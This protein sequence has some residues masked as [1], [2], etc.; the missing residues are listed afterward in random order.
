MRIAIPLFRLTLALIL[1]ATVSSNAAAEAISDASSNTL[2]PEERLNNAIKTAEESEQ[3]EKAT[4]DKLIELYKST[5]DLQKKVI[6]QNDATTDFIQSREQSRGKVKAILDKLQEQDS[7][8]ASALLELPDNLT[9]E[10]VEQLLITNKSTVSA[11]LNTLA[12]LDQQLKSQKLRPETIRQ[13][14]ETAAQHLQDVKNEMEFPTP[15]DQL[16]LLTE[17]RRWNLGARSAAL[18]SEIE[19][20]NQELL[21]QSARIELLKAQRIQAE[22]SIKQLNTSISQLEE[23]LIQQR[24]SDIEE[25]REK[26]HTDIKES[27][28]KHPLILE[29]AEENAVLSKELEQTTQDLEELTLEKEQKT[30]RVRAIEEDFRHTREKVEIAGYSQ[31][32]GHLLLDRRRNLPDTKSFRQ[33]AKTR[34][35]LMV[36]AG[37][38]QIRHIEERRD[39]R[40]IDSHIHQM[41]AALPAQEAE[42]IQADLVKLAASRRELLDSALTLDSAYLQTLEEV[43]RAYRETL[44]TVDSYDIFLAK[45]LLWVRNAPLPTIDNLPLTMKQFSWL[46][47]PSL[48]L[49][50]LHALLSSGSDSPVLGVG[51]I[52]FIILRWNAHKLR[53]IVQKSGKPVGKPMEDHFFYTFKALIAT[54]LLALPWPFLLAISGW[55]IGVSAEA[56]AFTKAISHSLLQTSFIFFYLRSFYI[57]C[58]PGGL[59]EAHFEWPKASVQLLRREFNRFMITFLP[60]IFIAITAFHYGIIPMEKGTGRASIIL[61]QILLG[62]FFYRLIGSK[63]AILQLQNRFP[64][65]L[66]ANKQLLWVS[67]LL[68]FPVA[69]I[70]LSILGYLY[71]AGV[72]IQNLLQTMWFSLA[73]VIVQQL[74]I[75]WLVLSHR[76][77]AFKALIE[78]RKALAADAGS[79]TTSTEHQESPVIDNEEEFDLSS[80]TQQS[81]KLLDV[82]LIFAAITGLWLIWS[83]VLPAI[84]LLD[85]ITLWHSTEIIAGKEQ[86]I[87]VTL[88]S[89]ALTIILIIVTI[90]AAKN[91]PALLEIVLRQSFGVLAGN[92]YAVTTLTKYLIATIGAII[93]FGNLGLKWSQLQWMVAALSVGIGFGLQEIIANFICGIII[94]FERPI[95]VGDFVTVGDSGDTSSDSSGTVTRIRIRATTILTRDRQELL[96]PNK[97][98][99]TGRL[100]NWSL[101]DQTI[102]IIL[103]VGIAYGSDVKTAM[104]LIL[105]VARANKLVLQEPEPFVTF[106]NF[107]D[108]SLTLNLRCYLESVDDRLETISQ[109]HE[110]INEKLIA[111]NIEIAFPQRDVHLDFSTP[112][113]VRLQGYDGAMPNSSEQ[114]AK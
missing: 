1:L 7:K 54:L 95:R 52:L 88:G 93:V 13:Q 90:V 96:V 112:L 70:T 64:D 38:R 57:I 4:K 62:V 77:L 85:E 22:E 50:T 59:A 78:H 47:S 53:H 8:D 6:F 82:A 79:A 92:R 99:I 107:G 81:R 11:T 67:L 2:V 23:K 63:S 18:N 97:E 39:L 44:D 33:K 113:D 94:L 17:A 74:A 103:P 32:L 56:T 3:L 80:L 9:M 60:T 89:I 10:G 75:R 87:A 43:D 19:M 61:T 26:A 101:S 14:L 86:H 46:L 15:A 51:L 45:H 98:F 30:A 5:I 49:E 110:G 73:L 36:K 68:F 109:L 21:G 12:R 111:A 40:D 20:L 76:R 25:A 114:P 41:T 55:Q 16:P 91:I 84:T 29:L 35:R 31:V 24:Q 27:A 48:W 71:S 105:Q 42:S 106:E 58:L 66:F 28:G 83:D 100:L 108:S 69:L 65:F 72:L 102:R 37:L 34:Q 104:A